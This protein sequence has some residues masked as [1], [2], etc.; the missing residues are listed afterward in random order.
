MAVPRQGRRGHDEHPL[1]RTQTKHRGFR[2]GVLGAQK[3]GQA[4]VKN[5]VLPE[6]TAKL[7]EVGQQDFIVRDDDMEISSLRGA[8]G[9]SDSC[10][11]D[12][13]WRHGSYLGVHRKRVPV[14]AK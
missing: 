2:S 7:H 5:D 8:K 1:A 4:A 11:Y 12:P 14:R 10:S 13:T 9:V 3:Q 6:H